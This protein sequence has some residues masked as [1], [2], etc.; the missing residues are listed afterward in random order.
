VHFK[1]LSFPQKRSIRTIS[2]IAANNPAKIPLT[3]NNQNME[4]TLDQLSPQNLKLL[5]E[6]ALIDVTHVE[7]PELKS[8]GTTKYW[9]WINVK[10][11]GQIYKVMPTDM[12]FMQFSWTIW[13]EKNESHPEEVLLKVS[14]M[15]DKFPVH[16]HYEGHDESDNT[17]GISFVYSQFF[18]DGES[19]EAR[20][21]LKIFKAFQRITNK[22]VEVYRQ[23]VSEAQGE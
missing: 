12:E 14:N 20:K 23:L 11:D 19:I 3:T 22:N 7:E 2:C 4:F 9:G 5:F 13:L 10:D 21:L 15:Y 17:V 8:D 6:Q 1:S 18:P 16:C